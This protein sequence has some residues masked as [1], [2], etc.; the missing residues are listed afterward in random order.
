MKDVIGRRI[1][2][3]RTRQNL[4]QDELI[5]DAQLGWERQTLGQVENGERELKA[6]EL[7][8]IS[9]V[10]RIDMSSFFPNDVSPTK[11][12]FVLWRQQPENHKRVEADFIRLC[13]DY[14]FLEELNS[15]DTN[16]FRKL[17]RRQID[18]RSFKYADTYALAEEI[19]SDLDLGDY[20]A[21]GLVKILEEK[22]GIKFFFNELDGNGSAASSA[23]D[24]GLCVLIS[25]SEP[26][27]RQHF[28]I[29]HEL[30]HI[31]SWDD[32]LLEQVY[33]SKEHW[34]RNESLAN[35]FAAGLLVPTEA[36]HREI[37]LLSKENKLN[38][39]GIVSIARQ[40]GVSLEAL[41]WRMAALNIISRDSVKKALTDTRLQ[42]LDQES[43]A[44]AQTPYYLSNRFVRMAYV[45]YENGEVSR[46]RLAKILNQSLS[47][48]PD[49]LKK[50]GLA[51]VSNN[52]IQLSHS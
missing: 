23:S 34:N 49:Y 26:A 48:L 12:P 16:G 40:F 4:T 3:E 30:F 28:S 29:A 36:L 20:P 18:L 35:A 43:R 6:W 32:S 42:A 37:R 19:R 11:Q 10:L 5:N 52:E 25:S 44:E 7:A 14:K 31:I 41:L 15:V 2:E 46:A 47:A 22:Y 8:K 21:T 39:A 45:A 9:Q 24:Y 50:F 17:P 27:W 51:E 33:S 13:K 1:K 38:D